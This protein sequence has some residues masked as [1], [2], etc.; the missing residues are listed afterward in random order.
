VNESRLEAFSSAA[1]LSPF[2]TLEWRRLTPRARLS[3][4][5]QMRSRLKNPREIH[6]RKLF[7]KP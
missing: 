4:S 3:R 7:P 1:A 5:W 2:K 6:D